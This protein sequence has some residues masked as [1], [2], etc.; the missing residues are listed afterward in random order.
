MFDVSADEQTLEE[1]EMQQSLQAAI[2]TVVQPICLESPSAPQVGHYVDSAGSLMHE[3]FLIPPQSGTRR[4]LDK[5]H[6]V[7][8]RVAPLVLG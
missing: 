2:E 7:L 1:E 4:N 3:S 8:A 5:P 6:Y